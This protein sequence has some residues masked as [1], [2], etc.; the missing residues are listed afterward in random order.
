VRASCNAIAAGRTATLIRSA[1]AAVGRGG[2][3]PTS[4]AFA[5]RLSASRIDDEPFG[6]AAGGGFLVA[7]ALGGLVRAVA[8]F[9]GEC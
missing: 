3:A 7:R 2:A 8:G 6:L 1:A 4:R 9:N 5:V